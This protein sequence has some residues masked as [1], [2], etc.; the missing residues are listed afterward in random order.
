M[1]HCSSQEWRSK[2]V[3]PCLRLDDSKP[4]YSLTCDHGR[5]ASVRL[6]PRHK[7][8]RLCTF[9]QVCVIQTR[10]ALL[11]ILLIQISPRC[12]EQRHQ[13]M[14]LTGHPATSAHTMVFVR[15]TARRWTGDGPAHTLL[16]PARDMSPST[17]H[18]CGR[19]NWPTLPK[20]HKHSGTPEPSRKPWHMPHRCN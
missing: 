1:Q 4:M 9:K 3:V 11:D 20:I 8:P 2:D 13:S 7:L 18:W 19:V 12:G 5:D 16:L 17:D 10:A 14:P 15:D 6:P